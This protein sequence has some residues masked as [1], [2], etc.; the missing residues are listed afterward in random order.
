MLITIDSIFS[1]S[2]PKIHFIETGH[3]PIQETNQA[4]KIKPARP[5]ASYNLR[6]ILLP[7]VTGTQAFLGLEKESGL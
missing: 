4:N 1:F 2:I 3:A 7:I 6:L 5:K